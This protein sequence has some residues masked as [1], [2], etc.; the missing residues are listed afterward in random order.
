MFCEKSA[1]TDLLPIYFMLYFY[2]IFVLFLI[3]FLL[4]SKH[5]LK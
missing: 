4:T 1:L 3:Y 2:F 5:A